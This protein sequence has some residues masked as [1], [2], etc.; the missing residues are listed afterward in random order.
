[1]EEYAKQTCNYVADPNKRTLKDLLVYYSLWWD[2]DA[3]RVKSQLPE[4]VEF[5]KDKIKDYTYKKY[6][7]EKHQFSEQNFKDFWDSVVRKS[8]NKD[9]IAKRMKNGKKKR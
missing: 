7:N 1:M 2:W 8:I 6:P 5:Y 3:E 4:A 9:A